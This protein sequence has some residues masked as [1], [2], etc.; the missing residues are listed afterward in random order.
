MLR[1]LPGAA[2]EGLRR[3]ARRRS[4]HRWTAPYPDR[5]L[6]RRQPG[7][8]RSRRGRSSGSPT[9]SVDVPE[10]FTVHPRGAAAAAAPRPDASTTARSTGR[11]GEI[12]RLRLAA[13]GGPP[14][15][16]GRPGHPAR[17]LRPAARRA[18]R[19]PQRR[20]V[21]AAAAPSPTTR[22]PFYVYDSLLSEYAAIGFEYGYSV[23][24]PD[25]LVLWEAQFGDF[26]NGAQTIID[27]F[28]SS[29]EAKWGQHSGVVLLLPHGYEGQGPDHSSARS[30]GSC[31]VRRGQHDRRRA[32]DA[33]HRTSTCCAAGHA[34][35]QAHGR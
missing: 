10:G 29:G 1:G 7:H 21:D 18:H 20:R 13:A 33:R 28:I 26:V 2:G 5:R 24:R 15:A 8:R 19:P 3:D 35:G 6:R 9:A 14:G 22:R 23:A 31:A 17:H 32:L 12:A 16:A 11:I 25:A 30:S 34:L 4:S 27:E